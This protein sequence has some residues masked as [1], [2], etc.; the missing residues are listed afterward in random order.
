M[1]SLINEAPRMLDVP[2]LQWVLLVLSV[3]FCAI[4]AG[5]SGTGGGALY[6]PVLVI[7][8]SSAHAA[9]PL[10]KVTILGC[11]VAALM[12][13]LNQRHSNNRQRHIINFEIALLIEPATLLGATFGVCLNIV[14]PAPAILLCLV[15]VCGLTLRRTIQKGFSQLKNEQRESK[16]DREFELNLLPLPQHEMERG[17]MSSS[18]SSATST[19]TPRRVEEVKSKIPVTEILLLG[20]DWAVNIAG[21]TVAG[22]AAALVCGQTYQ[23]LAT[24]SLILFHIGFL[25]LVTR[26]FLGIRRRRQLAGI[27]ETSVEEGGDDWMRPRKLLKY[28][29]LGAFI[30]TLAGTLGIG[31][32]LIKGPLL[33]AIGL[34]SYSAVATSTYMVVFTAST[35]SANY[36]QR[37][38]EAWVTGRWI[39]QAVGSLTTRWLNKK[40]NKQSV[41]TFILA[42]AIGLGLISM[43][44]SSIYNML[45]NDTFAGRNTSDGLT[46]EQAC[47]H[48]D[49]TPFQWF[50]SHKILPLLKHQ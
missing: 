17:L 47:R 16:S 28:I 7:F 23:R 34:S 3:F 20:L 21:L 42:S 18:S 45:K 41:T 26:R 43:T 36:L 15:V 50:L 4:L 2:P 48:L 31:G 12:P 49:V 32:G 40:Y 10:A 35:N 29:L 9:V 5:A 33:M 8:T 30:G 37:Q 6:M 38:L 24:F 44:F 1:Q 46:I 14:L 27:E 13:M 11:A 39:I 22:G 19:C 25:W